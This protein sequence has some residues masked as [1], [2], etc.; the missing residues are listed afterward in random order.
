MLDN[1]TGENV[2]IKKYEAHRIFIW[3]LQS[4]CVLCMITE[5]CAHPEG[6][7]VIS[8]SCPCATSVVESWMDVVFV[9]TAE[10]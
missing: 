5:P 9:G 4:C 1:H 7:H 10:L 3:T 6:V 2:L 8:Q